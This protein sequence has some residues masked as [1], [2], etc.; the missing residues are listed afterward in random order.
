MHFGC[1]MS[2]FVKSGKQQKRH[3]AQ[4]LILT[5][6]RRDCVKKLE[7]GHSTDKYGNRYLLTLIKG[8]SV[9]LCYCEERTVHLRKVGNV[10]Y[11][12]MLFLVF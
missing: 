10:C 2:K 8:E 9:K 3:A 6:Y 7:G 5:L 4:G 12:L 1:K 11:V